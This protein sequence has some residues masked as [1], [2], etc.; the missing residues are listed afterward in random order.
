MRVGRMIAAAILGFAFLLFVAMDL[1]LFGIIPLNSPA[2]TILALVGLIG[3][4]V[5]VAVGS[6]RGNSQTPPPPP[7]SV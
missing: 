1:V 2:V 3:G 6:A 4:P 7:P 5:L